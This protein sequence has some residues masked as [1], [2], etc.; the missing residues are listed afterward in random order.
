M[1]KMTKRER[2]M[3]AIKDEAVDRVPASYYNHNH[4]VEYSPDTLIPALLQHQEKF[5][6]DFVKVMLR[7]NYYL[8]AWG[9]TYTIDPVKGAILQDH[10]VKTAEDY[11]KLKKLDPTKGPFGENVEIARTLGAA[12][13]GEVPYMQSVFGPLTIAGRLAGGKFDAVDETVAARKFIDENPDELLEGLAVITET[14]A[15]YVREC[16]RAGADGIFYTTTAYGSLDVLTEEEYKIF[17]EPF[18][19]QV[20]R[21]A[22]EEGATLNILHI[23]R[24]N[25]M[26]DLFSKYPVQ[27][28]NYEST[29]PKNPDL[30]EVMTLTDKAIWGGMDQRKILPEDSAEAVKAQALDAL[31]Q[32]GGRRI[33]LGPG[34]TNVYLKAP[35]EN[36]SAMKEAVDTWQA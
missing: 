33:I 36:I 35:D 27:I 10:V 16:I 8:E 6:W 26:F 34:C 5:D 30:K 32:T 18:D 3:A 12:L 25:L 1:E 15:N 17:A 31:E 11:R 9:C 28:I 23:C 21:A 13:K 29:S 22:N 7:A 2:L 20:L 24:E 4:P 19:L 14:L